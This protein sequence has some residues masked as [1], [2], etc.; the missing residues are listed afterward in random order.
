M[1]STMA[2]VLYLLGITY[3]GTETGYNGPRSAGDFYYWLLLIP[4]L[5]YYF[6]LLKDFAK[7][8]FTYLLNW[9]LPISIIINLGSI[10]DEDPQW[11]FAT[12]FM[13]FGLY[14]FIGK[15]VPQF[16]NSLQNN[17]YRALGSLGMVVLLTILSFHFIW[18][19]MA[20]EAIEFGSLEAITTLLLLLVL[21]FLIFRITIPKIEWPIFDPSPFIPIVYLILFIAFRLSPVFSVVIINVILFLLALYTIRRAMQLQHL[22]LLNYGL[23]MITALIICRFFDTN[24]SFILRGLLFVIIGIGFFITNYRLIKTSR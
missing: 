21:S 15:N 1:P 7:S 13:L 9:L 19:E 16:H 22:G 6:S 24:I 8:N 18:K 2:A 10:A 14:Y 5:P 12:Y 17:G 11:L 3:Y 4:L 23:L 20:N